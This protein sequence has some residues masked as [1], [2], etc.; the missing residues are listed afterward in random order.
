MN[1]VSDVMTRGV[2]PLTPDDSMLQAAQAMEML[3]VGALPVCEGERLVGMVTDRDLVLRGLAQGYPPATRLDGLISRQVQSCHEDDAL[4]D[5]LQ[6]M[7]DTGMRRLPVLDGSQH[8]VGMVTLRDVAAKAVKRLG[9]ARAGEALSDTARPPATSRAG[10]R[11]RGTT[12]G[13]TAKDPS[14]QLGS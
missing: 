3:G 2:Q 11:T 13:G 12:R 4:D 1:K 5:V 14:Q 8:L 6:R 7:A 10:P 9:A